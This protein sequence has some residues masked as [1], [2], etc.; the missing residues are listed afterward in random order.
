MTNKEIKK[1]IDNRKKSYHGIY[2]DIGTALNS[3]STKD[4][5]K[6]FIDEVMHGNDTTIRA[7]VE[8]QIIANEI[9][10]AKYQH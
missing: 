8:D 1:L 3:V 6:Y 7:Y 9:N 4:L 5:I 10:K 2:S